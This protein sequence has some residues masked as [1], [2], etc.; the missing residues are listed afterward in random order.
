MKTPNIIVRE[1]ST[2]GGDIGHLLV[3]SIDDEELLLRFTYSEPIYEM[4]SALKDF[5]QYG[6]YDVVDIKI[7][8]YRRMVGDETQSYYILCIYYDDGR[9]IKVYSGFDEVLVCEIRS[10]LTDLIS[11]VKG[12]YDV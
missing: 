3:A 2:Y 7:S 12:V 10:A 9:V 1:F 6:D 4:S 5:V 8:H 11:Y